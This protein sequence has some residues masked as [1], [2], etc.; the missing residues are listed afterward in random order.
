MFR[1]PA[2]PPTNGMVHRW[3]WFMNQAHAVAQSLCGH[4]NA[5]FVASSLNK[6][7]C[8]K[9]VLVLNEFY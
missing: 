7:L 4:V 2:L 3:R 9:H 6:R 8:G 1:V 5:F